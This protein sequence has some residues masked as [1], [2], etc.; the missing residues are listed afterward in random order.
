[1]SDFGTNAL[2]RF[3]PEKET[4]RTFP[5][6]MDRNFA[7]PPGFELMDAP[8]R[9]RGGPKAMPAGKKRVLPVTVFTDYI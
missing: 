5:A 4:F 2:V 7:S 3:D 6:S 1:M 8:D 9:E